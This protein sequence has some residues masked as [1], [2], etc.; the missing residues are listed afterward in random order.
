MPARRPVAGRQ[1]DRAG[2]GPGAGRPRVKW[3]GIARSQTAMQAKR[4][5][6][7]GWQWQGTDNAL[8][9]PFVLRNPWPRVRVA[10]SST[11][12]SARKRCYC[13]ATRRDTGLP[14]RLPQQSGAT[15]APG[16]AQVAGSAADRK[17]TAPNLARQVATIGAI[18]SAHGRSSWRHVGSP[19]TSEPSARR[20]TSYFG[21]LSSARVTPLGGDQHNKQAA[22]TNRCATTGRRR[23]WPNQGPQWP[24]RIDCILD[25]AQCRRRFLVLRSV[26]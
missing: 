15:G 3:Q 14:N 10:R 19:A 13:G 20:V 8:K 1:M 26:D 2:P 4:L 22:S 5:I 12:S 9:L 23:L 24:T 17:Q 25:N 11:V 7:L 6:L 18:S 16:T 21:T